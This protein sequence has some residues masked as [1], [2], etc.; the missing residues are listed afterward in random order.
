MS[1][2]VKSIVSPGLIGG[3]LTV[4]FPTGM[5]IAFYAPLKPPDHPVPSGDRQMAR[6]LIAALNLWGHDARIVSRLRSYLP[7]SS[8][9]ALAETKARARL[10]VE[11]I[12]ASWR[13]TGPPDLWLSYHPYYKAP[14]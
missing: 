8:A 3:N 6:L 12:A 9:E 7:D 13:A 2:P 5:T 14:D 1:A 11:S 4:R 10:E